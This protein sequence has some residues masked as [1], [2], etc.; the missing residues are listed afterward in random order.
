MDGGRSHWKA[1]GPPGSQVEWDAIITQQIPNHR[2]EWMSEEGAPVKNA[3][4][5]HFTENR[6]G[7]T[8]VTINMSYTPPAGAL[9]HAVASLFGTDPKSAMDEDL[10]RMKT[11]LEEGKTSVEGREIRRGDLGFSGAASD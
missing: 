3:G 8:R 5:V 7:G 10:A 11:L 4:M 6:S 9:G 2:I 1:A